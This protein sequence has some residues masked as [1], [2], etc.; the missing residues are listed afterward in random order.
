MADERLLEALMKLGQL[1][2]DIKCA[3]GLVGWL[4]GRLAG[5]LET[6]PMNNAL[7]N[8]SAANT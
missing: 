4:A 3:C 6:V 1:R 2:L 5:K 8:W 7:E